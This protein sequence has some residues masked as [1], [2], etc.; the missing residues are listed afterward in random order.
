MERPLMTRRMVIMLVVVGL[1]L[2]AVFGFEAVRSYMV[3]KYMATAPPP[4]VAVSVVRAGLQEWQPHVSAVGTLR[5]MLGVDVTSEVSGLIQ[6]THFVS[7]QDAF[8]DQLLVQLDADTEIAQLRSLE[9][10]YELSKTV[11]ERDRKQYAVKAISRAALDAS[12]ADARVKGAQVAQQKT[13]IA[14]K[15]IRAPFAGRLGIGI[16][17]PGQYINPGEK[18]VTLQA[19]DPIFLDFYLP[20]QNLSRIKPGQELNVSSDSFPGRVFRGTITAMDPRV[21]Q[22]TRNF[23]VEATLGNPE[24]LLLPGMFA[25]V[26]IRTGR[27]ER[28]IT[29]PRTAVTYNPYG[30]TV[31]LLEEKGR[32]KSGK[33]VLTARQ[34]FVTVGPSRGDQVAILKGV[35]EGDLVITSGQQKLKSG[36][37]VFVNNRVQPLNQPY[38]KPVEE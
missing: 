38:P 15:F 2:G 23:Q 31:Y 25:S 19:L 34:T 36:S 1:V 9:A 11:L 18:I 20:Q 17:N 30:V 27:A 6:R 14:K 12:V 21:D 28:H 10:S 26:E 16:A 29:L 13:V 37:R 3:K 4:P 35:R 33:P 8:R 7:G 22:N 32:D 5:A 24:H